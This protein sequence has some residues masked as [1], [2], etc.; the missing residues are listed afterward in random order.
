MLQG[1]TPLLATAVHSTKQHRN[2]STFG[3]S[4]WIKSEADLGRWIRRPV[5]MMNLG[6]HG[7]SLSRL[8]SSDVLKLPSL[9]LVE[10]VF[11]LMDRVRAKGRQ[12]ACVIRN[13][14]VWLRF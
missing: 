9:R 3:T 12:T 14:A 7:I 2:K 6:V 10:T 5:S 8:T 11:L 1:K 4:T 13:A